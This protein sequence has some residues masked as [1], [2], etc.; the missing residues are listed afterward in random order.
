VLL[1]HDLREI[2]CTPVSVLPSSI[3]WFCCE[4]VKVMVGCGCQFAHYWLKAS[5]K[6][7]QERI[8]PRFC[9]FSVINML[10]SSTEVYV[11]QQCAPSRPVDGVCYEQYLCQRGSVA[12]FDF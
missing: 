4:K 6:Q 10:K 7:N 8:M 5:R 3:V 2:V 9:L 11:M 1:R 12:V